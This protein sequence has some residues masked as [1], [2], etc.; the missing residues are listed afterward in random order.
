MDCAKGCRSVGWNGDQYVCLRCSSFQ[1]QKC[2]G[3]DDDDC[4]VISSS[5]PFSPERRRRFVFVSSADASASVRSSE[6]SGSKRRALI[7][8]TIVKSAVRPSDNGSWRQTGRGGN[9]CADISP[10]PFGHVSGPSAMTE[11]YEIIEHC[12]DVERTW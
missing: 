12:C 4:C 2:T 6:A 8:P 9:N 3:P 7:Y 5:S 11:V 10:V 1:V